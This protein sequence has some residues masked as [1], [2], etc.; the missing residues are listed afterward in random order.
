MSF[1]VNFPEACCDCYIRVT[2]KGDI[3]ATRG[4]AALHWVELVWNSNRQKKLDHLRQ[5]KDVWHS[6]WQRYQRINSDKVIQITT[7]NFK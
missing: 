2:G 7:G 6:S 4:N 5:K 1:P 3:L